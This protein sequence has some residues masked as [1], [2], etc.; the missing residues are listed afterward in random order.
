MA[1]ASLSTEDGT[2]PSS[3]PLPSAA[4]P[5][6]LLCTFSLTKQYSGD[7]LKFASMTS[8]CCPLTTDSSFVAGA[9][10]WSAT[11][12]VISYT[13]ACLVMDE[14]NET[15]IR[16]MKNGCRSRARML[17]Q[18]KSRRQM[19]R[20]KECVAA[21]IVRAGEPSQASD[22]APPAGDINLVAVRWLPEEPKRSGRVDRVLARERRPR[23]RCAVL[24]EPRQRYLASALLRFGRQQSL[25]AIVT[26]AAHRALQF[27]PFSLS[28]CLCSPILI[29][30]GRKC[31]L[32][33]HPSSRR[34]SRERE[35]NHFTIALE[36]NFRRRNLD[37]T[38]SSIFIQPLD[39]RQMLHR[40]R[41][42]A[43]WWLSNGFLAEISERMCCWTE[44]ERRLVGVA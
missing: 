27:I 31:P 24:T 32:S 12:H 39:R 43:D 2:T 36:S 19:E 30:R 42:I 37:E 9:A 26:G 6:P 1:G 8:T 25:A 28:L 4:A 5:L 14:R 33:T 16:S 44:C 20:I 38:D 23:I 21:R 10:V 15:K 18:C 34:P 41:T 7:P 40:N 13:A 22:S 17:T 11:T 35:R 29:P 3:V